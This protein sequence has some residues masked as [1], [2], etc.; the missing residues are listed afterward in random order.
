MVYGLQTTSN[1]VFN[2][3]ELKSL[4]PLWQ[5]HLLVDASPFPLQPLSLT[6]GVLLGLS[7]LGVQQWEAFFQSMW[8]TQR[9]IPAPQGARSVA[10]G[11]GK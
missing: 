8:R 4:S 1:E 11:E 7:A 2:F 6:Q 5:R 3:S 9:K 10:M